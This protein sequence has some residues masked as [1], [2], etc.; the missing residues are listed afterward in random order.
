M[1][2]FLDAQNMWSLVEKVPKEMGMLE[3]HNTK[4]SFLI[5]KNNNKNHV[6]LNRS[7]EHIAG[8]MIH[9]NKNK[10]K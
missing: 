5:I 3:K 9:L 8:Y 6:F 2:Q 7:N 10:T 1:Y 4:V